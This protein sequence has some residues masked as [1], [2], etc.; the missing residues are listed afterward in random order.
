M[1]AERGGFGNEPLRKIE[2]RPENR[3]AQCPGKWM[4][5][6]EGRVLQPGT[7]MLKVDRISASDSRISERVISLLNLSSAQVA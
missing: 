6:T 3:S 5:K 7:R 1:L 2:E 4:E